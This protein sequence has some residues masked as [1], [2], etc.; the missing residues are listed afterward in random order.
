MRDE[1]GRG[2]VMAEGE[3]LER[4]REEVK[5]K[6]LEDETHWVIKWRHCL[7]KGLWKNV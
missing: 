6:C 3:G 7:L 4:V 5:F 1:G 2:E